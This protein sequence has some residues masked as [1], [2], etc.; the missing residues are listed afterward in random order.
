MK[1]IPSRQRLGSGPATAR[2]EKR[3]AQRGPKFNSK[4]VRSILSIHKGSVAVIGGVTM[5][6]AYQ[7]GN[8]ILCVAVQSNDCADAHHER[9]M[10][11]TA[12]LPAEGWKLYVTSLNGPHW[13]K[14]A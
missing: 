10:I 14:G 4:K 8:Q 9:V 1:S 11:T 2:D 6:F 13:E 3:A 5:Q 12:A 7:R